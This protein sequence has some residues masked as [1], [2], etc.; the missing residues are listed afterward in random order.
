MR[1]FC[2]KEKFMVQ[3]AQFTYNPFQENTYVV[4]DDTRSCVIFD[5]GCSNTAEQ[6]SI[7]SF[8]RTNDLLPVRLINTHCHI[9]HILGNRYIAERFGLELEIHQGEEAMLARG[10]QVAAMYGI[11]YPAPSPA[12]GRYIADLE[13]IA[14]GNTRMQALLTPG[15]SPA[16]LCFYF[17]DDQ[18][19]I[20]GDVLFQGSIG[21]TDLPGG[22]YDTLLH[23]IHSRLLVLDDAVRVFPGHGPETTIGLERRSNPFLV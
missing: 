19:L 13:W 12:P 3:V 9:D 20:A 14:F 23:S 17:P 1:I 2:H 22:D 5:P 10:E 21:R 16:S 11:P 7:D 18:L 15:H 6:E 8:I 4:Y